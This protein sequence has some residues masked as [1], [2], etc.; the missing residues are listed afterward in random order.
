MACHG[1]CDRDRIDCV[2]AGH[3]QPEC[4]EKCRGWASRARLHISAK[5]DEIKGLLTLEPVTSEEALSA[6]VHKELM[7]LVTRVRVP[8]LVTDFGYWPPSE[9]AMQKAK[10]LFDAGKRVTFEDIDR[11][12]VVQ[13]EP[14][15]NKRLFA[16][17]SRIQEIRSVRG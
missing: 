12:S 2:R 11:H 7:S 9:E 14:E 16:A 3:I 8:R 17:R 6:I 10:A 4:S 5:F 1:N 13:V 15:R